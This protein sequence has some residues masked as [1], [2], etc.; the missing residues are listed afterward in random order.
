MKEEIGS[1]MSGVECPDCHG[2]RLKPVVLAVTIGDKNISEFCEM[3]IR[4]ELRFIENER[5]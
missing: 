1:F 4:D 2:R 5:I 3:S